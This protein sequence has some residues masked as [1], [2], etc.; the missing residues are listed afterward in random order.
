MSVLIL[1]VLSECGFAAFL[2]LLGAWILGFLSWYFFGKS[3]NNSR[4]ADSEKRVKRLQGDLNNS[5]LQLN[6]TQAKLTQLKDDHQA[7]QVSQVVPTSQGQEIIK[8]VPVEVIKEIEVIREVPV[9]QEVEVI[10][11]KPIIKEVE[12][13]REIEVVREV[14]IIQEVEII[15]E[16]EVIKEVPVIQEIEVVREVEVPKV[17]EVIK[18]V[19]VEVVKEVEVPKIVEVI[20]EVPVEVVKE[21]EVPK[22]VEVI[23]EV[24]IEVIREVE[25]IKK[26]EVIKEV[27]IH[28][29]SS[30]APL[31]VSSPT[32]P[33]EPTLN[34]ATQI[35][36]DLRDDDFKI[37]EGIGP[38][39]EMILKQ[40][41]IKTWQVLSQMT[42]DEIQEILIETGGE[43]YK[44]HDPTTWPSQA[45]LASESRW[46]ELKAYQNDLFGGKKL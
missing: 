41:E 17:I 46:E 43:R 22:I 36:G 6:Q 39:I 8:E 26:V 27:P 38:K 40:A 19:P 28:L 5:L 11:E 37:I 20:K 31:S 21:V 44:M 2:W 13:I 23:K 1:S 14:P 42:P 7:L 34:P 3:R 30:A 29:S 35:L 33:E 32:N 16:V 4:L 45:K 25:V 18:E 10:R 15:K 9:V 24:P 12:V